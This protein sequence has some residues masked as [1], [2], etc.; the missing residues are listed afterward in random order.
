MA[1]PQSIMAANYQLLLSLEIRERNQRYVRHASSE[2]ATSEIISHIFVCRLI[3]FY[4]QG[5]SPFLVPFGF[6]TYR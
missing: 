1:A 2:R 4:G 6:W 3:G 5:Q